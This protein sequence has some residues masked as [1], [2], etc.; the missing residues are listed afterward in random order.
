MR[1][2]HFVRKNLNLILVG[3]MTLCLTF[4][5]PA[6]IYAGPCEDAAYEAATTSYHACYLTFGDDIAP[7]YAAIA[8]AEA[9]R[10]A[11]V[12]GC[13][14]T[15]AALVTACYADG[16]LT[17]EEADAIAFATLECEDCVASYNDAYDVAAAEALPIATAAFVALYACE[18]DSS[19]ELTDA[20]FLCAGF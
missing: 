10:S 8:A 16:T 4:V 3:T 1:N 2:K 20:L 5:R 11:G 9:D 14:D 17:V 7:Y 12:Q 15:L 6:S 13:T 18:L 19:N